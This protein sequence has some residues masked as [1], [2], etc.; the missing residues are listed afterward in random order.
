MSVVILGLGNVLQADEG[1]G[2]HAARALAAHRLPHV[3]VHE[4]GSPV[5]DAVSVLE[6]ATTVIV[7]DA[8]DAGEKPGTIVRFDLDPAESIAPSAPLH[9]LDLP[10]L[11]RTLPPGRRPRVLV[12]GIQPSVMGVGDGLSPPVAAS[13]GR[14]VQ[15]VKEL[16]RAEVRESESPIVHGQ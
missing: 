4:V 3:A 1:V 16:A 6:D 7:V 12:V 10:A 14:L 13:L 9:D 11:M 2:V 8:I 15:M 5:F